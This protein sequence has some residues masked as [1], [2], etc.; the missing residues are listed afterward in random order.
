M[1]PDQSALCE[2]IKRFGYA[3]NAKVRLYGRL[4]EVISD[5]VC[6]GDEGVSVCA[7]DLKS[8]SSASI[9]IPLNIVRMAGEGHRAA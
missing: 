4:L 2:T 5:P 1:T 8:G 3:K 7:R 9:R 6:I